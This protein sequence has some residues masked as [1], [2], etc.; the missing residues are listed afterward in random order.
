MWLHM[1]LS[2]GFNDHR[3]FPFTQLRQHLGTKWAKREKE[4]DN[5]EEL[6]AFAAQKVSELD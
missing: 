4:F 1:L 3:S 6:K 2:S 5:A